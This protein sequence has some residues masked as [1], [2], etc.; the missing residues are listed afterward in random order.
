[1]PT[2][3]VFVG[4]FSAVSGTPVLS[5]LWNSRLVGSNFPATKYLESTDDREYPCRGRKS[6]AWQSTPAVDAEVE[7]HVRRVWVVDSAGGPRPQ[8]EMCLPRGASQG[9]LGKGHGPRRPPRASHPQQ[10]SEM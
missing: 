1:M 5:S 8:G 4:L 2:P 10:T 9:L 6:R 3:L 7:R